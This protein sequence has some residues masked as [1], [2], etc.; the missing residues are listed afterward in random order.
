MSVS[1]DQTAP[2]ASP[3]SKRLPRTLM[4][5]ETPLVRFGD[6]WFAESGDWPF[7]REMAEQCASFTLCAPCWHAKPSDACAEVNL[8]AAQ[9]AERA[10]SRPGL[11][12][13]DALPHRRLRLRRQ[14]RDLAAR[15]DLVL[16]EMPS[17][18]GR[19]AARAADAER[20]PIV[21]LLRNGGEEDSDPD[22][23]GGLR[24]V[25][26]G[27][28]GR[29]AVEWVARRARLC[30]VPRIAARQRLAG[31][32]ARVE[33]VRRGALT[34][35][36]LRQRDDTCRGSR[37]RLAC[38]TPL[39]PRHELGPLLQAV[40][41]LVRANRDVTLDVIGPTVSHAYADSVR[42]RI[43]MLGL[44][45]RV[46]FWG[47]LE[48]GDERLVPLRSADIRIMLSDPTD[49]PDALLDAW[50]SCVPTIT[51]AMGATSAPSAESGW[52]AAASADADGVASAI[53]RMMDDDELRRGIIRRGFDRA[54]ELTA[55]QQA[56]RLAAI[57][58]E[59]L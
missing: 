40:S 26:S 13:L 28:P 25:L 59:M 23:P 20:K 45:D 7:I 15:H 44:S 2:P 12:F 10:A 34:D 31:I 41:Q 42:N 38:Q 46:I 1:P 3:P 49:L 32:A 5:V 11:G 6:R 51:L 21:M 4:V 53:E 50:A 57:L 35:A 43:D 56:R 14:V 29:R 8:G 39:A 17:Q 52:L 22:A 37:I 24:D 9:V 54:R 18:A 16:C 55:E 36:Q 27:R 58:S 33:I 19:A 30:G 48:R 47:R